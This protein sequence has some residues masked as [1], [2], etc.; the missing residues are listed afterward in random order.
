MPRDAVNTERAQG[1][2]SKHLMQRPGHNESTP[3][4]TH[5]PAWRWLFFCSCTV[6]KMVEH[7]GRSGPRRAA[8]PSAAHGQTD[9]DAPRLRFPTEN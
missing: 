6:F 4:N 1:P 2:L 5:L 8:V 9:L 7:V 3:A